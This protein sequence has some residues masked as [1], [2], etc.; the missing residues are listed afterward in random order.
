MWKWDFHQCYNLMIQFLCRIL[1]TAKR[2]PTIQWKLKSRKH[3]WGKFIWTATEWFI[4]NV[5]S[6]SKFNNI[7]WETTVFLIMGV[8]IDCMV[9]MLWIEKK[10][11]KSEDMLIHCDVFRGADKSFLCTGVFSGRRL[12]NAFQQHSVQVASSCHQS[13]VGQRDIRI[14]EGRTGYQRAC[15]FWWWSFTWQ[16]L[17]PGLNFEQSG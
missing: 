6:V 17:H 7:S 13:P 15:Q 10:L 4:R 2:K 14:G 11:P 12:G 9:R 1:S 3:Y 8:E 5:C 16:K